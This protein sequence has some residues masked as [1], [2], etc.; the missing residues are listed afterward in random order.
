MMK[1][2]QK[3]VLIAIVGI[4][5]ISTALYGCA[6]GTQR[7]PGPN[8][9]QQ[10][11]NTRTQGINRNNMFNTTTQLGQ[12]NITG[13]NTGNYQSMNYGD[14]RY[15]NQS[16]YQGTNQGMN[17][18]NSILGNNQGN[19]QG[20][21]LGNNRNIGQTAPDRRKAESIKRQLLNMNGVADCDVI[22]MGN[23]ALV[24]F[25]PSGRRGDANVV[26]SSIMNK[27]RQIDSTITNVTVSESSD[28]MDRMRRLGTDITNNR[29]INAI[30]DEFN[31]LIDGLSPANR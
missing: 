31:K 26:R 12:G 29:P 2:K 15:Y 28:I 8:A 9:G 11:Q 21:N 4:C 20:M 23:N 22:V 13:G 14:N 1:L 3:T 24:G 10:L 7:A 27:V 5:L 17:R 16:N 18:R 30:T 19:Y 25:R 6:A